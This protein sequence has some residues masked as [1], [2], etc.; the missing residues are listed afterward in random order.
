MGCETIYLVNR[1]PAEAQ[2]LTAWCKSQGYSE[3]LRH[4]VTAAEAEALEGA[5]AIV[6]RVPSFPPVREA[7]IEARKTMEVFLGK[8]HKG[9][10]LEMCYHPTPYTEVGDLAK[11]A[12]WQ[13]VLGTESMLYQGFKQNRF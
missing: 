13:I 4:V 1:E 8:L 5:G 6:A 2:A 9:D 3:C 12:G 7:K 11:H 10:M